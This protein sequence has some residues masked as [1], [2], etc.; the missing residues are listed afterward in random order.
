MSNPA[1]FSES[2]TFIWQ[3]KV[4]MKKRG[5]VV[6]WP[7]CPHALLHHLAGGTPRRFRDGLA[8]EHSRDFLYAFRVGQRPHVGDRPSA[9]DAL[10]HHVVAVGHRGDLRQVGYAQHLVALGDRPQLAPYDLRHA[11]PDPGVHLVE[12]QRLALLGV[13]LRR[14]RLEREQ[15]PRQL[16]SRSDTREAGAPP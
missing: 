14:H 15:N 12:D 1:T 11:A 10:A 4:W 9:L 5:I 6:S 8:A 16:S 2:F 3:P 13:V 7:S